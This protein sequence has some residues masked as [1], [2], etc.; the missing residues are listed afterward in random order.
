M[1][2]IFVYIPFK[3]VVLSCLQEP[4]FKRA[5]PAQRSRS[6]LI[7]ERASVGINRKGPCALVR[8]SLSYHRIFCVEMCRS[9]SHNIV[10]LISWTQRWHKL[11][12]RHKDACWSGA[13]THTHTHTHMHS[14]LV[15]VGWRKNE[16]SSWASCVLFPYERREWCKCLLGEGACSHLCL[17]IRNMTV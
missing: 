9:V 6:C 10:S 7:L 5:H 14:W 3:I 17:C 16:A 11:I 2:V 13:H 1:P 15:C 8:H 12:G 4:F